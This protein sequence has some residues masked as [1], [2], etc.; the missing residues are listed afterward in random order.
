MNVTLHYE[1]G[2]ESAEFEAEDLETVNDVAWVDGVR[3]TDV[4]AV[5]VSA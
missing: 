3:H 1:D 5:D 2:S 4:G